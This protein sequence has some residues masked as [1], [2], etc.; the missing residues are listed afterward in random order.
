LEVPFLEIY[1]DRMQALRQSLPF[2]V[3]KHVAML[4]IDKGQLPA[5]VH[6]G[7]VYYGQLAIGT[8]ICKKFKG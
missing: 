1:P 3:I 4:K 5:L 2:A 6:E 8:Y 7:S